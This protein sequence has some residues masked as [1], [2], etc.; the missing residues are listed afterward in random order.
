MSDRQVLA[1]ML[2]KA[3]PAHEWQH[4]RVDQVYQSLVISTGPD[5]ACA[6]FFFDDEG[7]L[8]AVSVDESC[9]IRFMP[10]HDVRPDP[11]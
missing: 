3:R 7:T 2:R 10:G 5:D 4:V 9:H 1:E 8:D 6:V 11:P